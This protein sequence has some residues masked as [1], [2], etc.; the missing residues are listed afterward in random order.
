MKGV[1]N[2]KHLSALIIKFLIIAVILEIL[3]NIT[4]DLDF[5]E[6]LII[7]LTVTIVAYL[8]G[9]LLILPSSN[10][11]I[12]TIS[13]IGLSL[14]II[15]LFNYRYVN[16]EISFSDALISAVVIGAGEW[17]FHKFMASG[18]LYKKET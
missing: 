4:T 18:V 15:L 11:I 9:D 6:I 16:T 12:A 3:L 17:F 8:L 1:L 2:I 7:S 10:N 14:I 13:D 5:Y